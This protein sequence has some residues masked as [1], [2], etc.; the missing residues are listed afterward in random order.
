L[1]VARDRLDAPG[2]I[3]QKLMAYELFLNKYPR[4]RDNVSLPTHPSDL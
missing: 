2:G 4:W 1:I 3:K